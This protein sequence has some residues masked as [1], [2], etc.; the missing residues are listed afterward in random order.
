MSV[1]KRTWGNSDGSSGEA[2]V[3]SYTDQAGKRRIKSFDRKRDAD[4]YHA[5]VSTDLRSGIHVPDSESIM[6]AEAGRLWLQSCEAAGLE[7]TTLVS[8]REHLELHII[9][10]IGAVKLTRLTVPM[11]RAFEDKL[12][13]H[14]SRAMVKKVRASLGAVLADAQ[15]RGL[16]GQNVVRNLRARRKRGKEVRADRRQKGKLKI[17]VHIPA[18]DEIRA[19]VHALEDGRWRPL[20]LT[21]I[22]SGLRASEL[23][24]LRWP[25]VD[26]KAGELHVRQRADYYK[27]LGQPKSE[28]GERTIPLPPMV[29]AAL[30][31]WRLACPKGPLNL[32][33]PNGKG[34]VENLTN[35]IGRGLKPA[36]IAAG[37][38]SPVLDELGEPAKDDEAKPL[39]GAKYSGMHAL[40]HFYASW[41]I[42][43]RVDGGLELPL[44]VVSARLGHST[45]TLTADRYGHLFPR[46]DDGAEL[47]AAE[48]VFLGS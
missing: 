35:I 5:S 14:R 12:A 45:I 24:G 16:V 44:K 1:R 28:S 20:F 34:N 46:G 40:R 29:V 43:R 31:T 19:L 27:K 25:D 30:R 39:I 42:N 9:P 33:F 2:W 4:D 26:L 48:Q 11:V 15:E 22:F 8:Y 7:L 17:G 10:L 37:V 23:R 13:L 21:A 3:A 6:V 36:M 18:P 41:C 38:T 47:A 32:V